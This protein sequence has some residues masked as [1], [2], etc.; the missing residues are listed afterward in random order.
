M[1]F[2]TAQAIDSPSYVDVPLPISSNI[3]R[4]LL[5]APRGNFIGNDTYLNKTSDRLSIITGPNMAGKTSSFSSS[6]SSW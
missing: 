4:L 1:Y 5:V 3:I 6:I 2:A